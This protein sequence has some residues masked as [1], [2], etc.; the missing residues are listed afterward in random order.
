MSDWV[1]TA[2]LNKYDYDLFDSI[3]EHGDAS[4][5]HVRGCLGNLTIELIKMIRVA[6]E[7]YPP[8]SKFTLTLF[9]VYLSNVSP[10]QDDRLWDSELKTKI[11]YQI[12][13]Y[14]GSNGMPAYRPQ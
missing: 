3:F 1:W 2:N 13:Y 8:T 11:A 4:I 5:A 14:R 10:K 12:G 7:L 6:R 9:D